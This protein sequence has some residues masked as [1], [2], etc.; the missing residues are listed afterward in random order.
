MSRFGAREGQLT[1]PDIA[2]LSFRAKQGADRAQ[3]AACSAKSA[4]QTAN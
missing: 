4:H 3:V 1:K 2:S